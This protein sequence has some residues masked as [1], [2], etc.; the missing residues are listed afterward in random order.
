MRWRYV[1][2]GCRCWLPRLPAFE[3]LVFF[4]CCLEPLQ[5]PS[6]GRWWDEFLFPFTVQ[7]VGL[8]FTVV[9]QFM[10]DRRNCLTRLAGLRTY[11]RAC[12]E[13]GRHVWYQRR[14]VSRSQHSLRWCSVF[15]FIHFRLFLTW[16]VFWGLSFFFFGFWR[17]V[18][19]SAQSFWSLFPQFFGGSCQWYPFTFLRWPAWRVINFR[20]V[21]F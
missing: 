15:E 8:P 13:S 12:Q 14:L 16:V 10:K 20:N 7:F 2:L 6:C 9:S 17:W 5:G 21:I 19:S 4:R 3:V 18:C 1:K 11:W